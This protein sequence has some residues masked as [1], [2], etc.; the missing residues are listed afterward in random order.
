[1]SSSYS[2]VYGSNFKE[3]PNYFSDALKK[4]EPII[5]DLLKKMKIKLH[6]KKLIFILYSVAALSE[7]DRTVQ[8][9]IRRRGCNIVE[10]SYSAW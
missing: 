2:T 8:R 7:T 3:A 9:Y 10:R 4:F 5:Q 6:C 1:M